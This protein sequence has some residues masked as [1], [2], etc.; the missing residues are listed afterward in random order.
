MILSGKNFTGKLTI[1]APPSKSVCH[2]ELIIRFLCGDTS[3]LADSEE[4]NED[5]L[6][7]K[8]CLRSLNEASGLTNVRLFCNESGSTLRFMIPVACAYL[9]REGAEGNV[10]ELIFETKGR[11]FDRPIKELADALSPHGI[12]ITKEEETRTIHAKGTMRAGK[13]V[14]DGSVSSQY[15]SGLLMALPLMKEACSIEV[16]GEMKSVHYLNLTLNALKKYNCPTVV[17]GNTFLPKQAGYETV[18]SLPEFHVEGDWSNGAFLLCLQQFSDIDVT[19]L[20]PDSAQGDKAIL[21]FLQ[22]AEEVRVNHLAADSMWECKDIPDIV[23]YMAITA[24]FIYRKTEFHDIDRLRI[25]ESDRVKAVREQLSAVGI[26]TEETDTTLTVYGSSA[27]VISSTLAT[28]VKLSSYHDHRMAMCAILLAVILK[29]D[30]EL[31]DLTCVKK[32][33][34]ELISFVEKYLA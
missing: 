30:V 29:T 1:E 16:M 2:R 34:P 27:E 19:N 5:I 24:A 18:T 32:S 6:A 20:N 11:L 4:D 12:T 17:E 25:K 22:S 3:Y 23:P 31:D 21:N 26:K 7:T 28:P 8:S 15:I 10:T 14:I 33:Y 9:L 13:Y